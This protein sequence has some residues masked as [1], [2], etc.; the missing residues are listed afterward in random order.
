LGNSSNR[1]VVSSFSQARLIAATT[2][3]WLCA[4]RGT[5]LARI[6]V[7]ITLAVDIRASEPLLEDESRPAALPVETSEPD[8]RAEGVQRAL[9]RRSGSLSTIPLL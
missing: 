4:K 1:Q 2:V 8:A 3:G 7:E 9:A 6:K 5:P